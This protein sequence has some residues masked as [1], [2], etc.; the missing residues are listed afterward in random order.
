MTEFYIVTRFLTFPG[1]VTRAFW[2]QVVCRIHKTAVEDNR[3]LRQDEMC[4]H[5]EHELMPTAGRAFAVCFVPMLL[6]IVL[7]FLVATPA[8]FNLLYLGAFSFPKGILD[9]VC[10]WIGFSLVVN[11]FPSI[12]DAM[13]MTEKIYKGQANIFQK[14]IFALGT[15]ICYVGAFLERYCVTFLTS[16]ALMIWCILAI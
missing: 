16:V 7:A 8:A 6:Q 4:S 15:G 11:C 2:E 14:I 12:E 1:A 9:V 3:Y 13:N 5:V 10:L